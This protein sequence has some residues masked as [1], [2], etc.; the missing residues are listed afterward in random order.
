VPV[1]ERRAAAAGVSKLHEAH[2]TFVMSGPREGEELPKRQQ[3]SLL[4]RAA[5]AHKLLPPETEDE[6][7]EKEAKRIMGSVVKKQ[8]LRSI[9]ENAAGVVYREPLKT[10]WHPPSWYERSMHIV[11]P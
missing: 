2:A 7:L 3:T 9:E 4:Q 8:A 10:G 1:K 11:T 6:K 5:A